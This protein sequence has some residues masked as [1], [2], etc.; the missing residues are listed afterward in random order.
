MSTTTLYNNLS[1][2]NTTKRKRA[3]IKSLKD[4]FMTF[5]WRGFDAFE[6]FGAFIINEKKGSLKFY[7]GLYLTNEYTKPQFDSNVGELMGVNF[8]RRKI[9]FTIG[10]YWISIEHYR[11]LLNWLDPMETSTLSFG[12]NKKYGYVVKLAK[13]ADST[14]HIVGRDENGEAMYYTELKL[15]FELQGAQCAVGLHPYEFDS[16][17]SGIYFIKTSISDFIESDLPTPVEVS[18]SIA[19]STHQ[20]TINFEVEESI[21]VKNE[22]TNETKIMKTN[23]TLFQA[24][25]A[26]LAIEKD[27]E[28][29]IIPYNITYNSETGILYIKYG[30]TQEKILDLITTTD[31]GERL[32][33]SSTSS[34]FMLPGQFNYPGFSCSNL[35]FKCFASKEN[36]TDTEPT[37]E[38]TNFIC[39]PRTNII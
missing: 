12:F 16:T 22:E 18:F 25:L 32:L 29:K 35:I 21:E 11:L 38:L 10:V 36:D 20:H 14:R 2:S 33:I 7:N 19:P 13:I 39:Y 3:Q 4:E 5:S 31:T 17:E 37:I 24:N 30:N 6:N 8:N 15:S 9:D 1:L 23:I 26:N 27:K 28:D 34:K